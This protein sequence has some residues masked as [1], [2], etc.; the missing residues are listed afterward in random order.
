PSATARSRPPRCSA[1]PPGAAAEAWPT[2]R[3][4]RPAQPSPA[5]CPP[6]PGVTRWSARCA[7]AARPWA[8]SWRW[9]ARRAASTPATSSC[10]RPGGARG[11]RAPP[12]RGFDPTHEQLLA[13]LPEPLAAAPHNDRRYHEMAQ[14]REA[15]EA[16]NR[17]LLSRL[18]REDI[19]DSVVG[20]EAGLR[21]VM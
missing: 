4:A 3:P 16:D 7:T 13:P 2:R 21:G 5:C 10:S 17:A 19:S 1:S 11:A 6:A 20:A 8:P 12:P 18:A 14:L 15:T 9:P